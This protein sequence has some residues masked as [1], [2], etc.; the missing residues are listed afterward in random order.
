VNHKKTLSSFPSRSF[1]LKFFEPVPAWLA[2]LVLIL[3]TALGIMAG[4][5]K[6]LN[7]AFPIGAVAVGTLFYFKYPIFYISFTWWMWFLSPL[8]RRL[9]DYRSTYTEPSPLLL[10]PYLV[11]AITLV[12]VLK[13]LPKIRLQGSFPFVLALAGVFYGFLIGLINKP[14]FEVTRAFLDWLVPLTFGFH[15]LVNWQ[16]F[17]AY[18]QNIQR[19]FVWGILGMGIYGAFQ[20]SALPEWDRLWL[21]S[22][23]MIGAAGTPTESGGMR[24]WSTMQSGEQFAAFMAS[25]LLLLFSHTGV[26]S[27]CAS[28]FGYLGLLLSTVRSAWIGWLVGLITLSSSLKGKQQIRLIIIVAVVAMIVIPLATQGIFSEKIG[29]RLSTFSNVNEDGSVEIRQKLLMGSIES[30]L[31]SYVGQGIGGGW[32]DSALLTMFF[33]LGWI[34]TICYVSGLLSLV[35]KVFQNHERELDLFDGTARAIIMSCLIRIP[36]NGTSI[37]GVGGLLLWGF[38]GLSIASQ[39]YYQQKRFADLSQALTET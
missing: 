19:T 10:A 16:N 7:L 35:L 32:A 21:I 34:G 22:S 18:Y 33:H 30:A 12:T 28:A 20:F 15:L 39:K 1:S 29:D 4:A 2:I 31:T 26:L 23:N 13:N 11:T 6:I 24:V 14:P 37:G 3:S 9:I 5:S 38:L 36:V 17:P 27:L 8:V 25:G